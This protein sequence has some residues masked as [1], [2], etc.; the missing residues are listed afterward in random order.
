VLRRGELAEWLPRDPI[1]RLERRL[2]VRGV[3]DFEERRAALQA[4]V[5][6]ALAAA[7][8]AP[9]PSP[10]RVLDFVGVDS[11]RAEFFGAESTPR[12]A[13]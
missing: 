12:E 4:E 9:A 3:A 2:A 8:A 13:A 10:G 5:S 11:N 6:R 7:R 1:A